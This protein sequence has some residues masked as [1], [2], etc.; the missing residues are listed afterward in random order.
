MKKN[1]TEWE[2]MGGNLNYEV[3]EKIQFFNVKCSNRH[4]TA[5]PSVTPAEH[6]TRGV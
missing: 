5:N 6:H 3:T 1:K 4:L 2:Q